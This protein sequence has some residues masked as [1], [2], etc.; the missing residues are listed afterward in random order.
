M[1]YRV[2]FLANNGMLTSRDF[3]NSQ[4]ITV[5]ILTE[6]ETE[7]NT[8]INHPTITVKAVAWSLIADEA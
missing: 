2:L 5:T 7:V 4:T 6:W 8:S 3:I 1:N